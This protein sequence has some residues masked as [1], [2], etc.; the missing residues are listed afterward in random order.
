MKSSADQRLALPVVRPSTRFVYRMPRLR[1]FVW[2]IAPGPLRRRLLRVIPAALVHGY[3]Q[4]NDERPIDAS[5]F[6]PDFELHQA[7]E[8]LG[9]VGSF[10]GPGALGSVIA[11]VREGFDDVR[12][13]PEAVSRVSE[14]VFVVTVRFGGVGRGS[15]VRL[16]H[17]IAHVWTIRNAMAARLE[18]YW[19]PAEAFKAAAGAATAGGA[20]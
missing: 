8:M 15:G 2:R 3:R 9:T 5:Q 13:V 1:S 7:A 20:A 14:E 16:D 18:V 4:F 19:E 10:N 17:R 12:F 11:E 6:A